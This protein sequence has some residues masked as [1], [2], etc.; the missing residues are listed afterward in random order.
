MRIR[1]RALSLINKFL[2]DDGS[3]DKLNFNFLGKNSHVISPFFIKN[4]Q[5]I[6]IGENFS[7]LYNLRL[8]AWDEYVGQKFK[9]ELIIGNNVC[10]N[11][12]V[13]IGCIDRIEIG[14]NVLMASRIFIADCS[15]GHISREALRLPP[16]QRP[17][18][19]KG[20]VIIENNVW[21]GEGV[22]ILH[23]VTI[24]E[25]SIIGANSVITKDIPSNS[26]VGGNPG[27]ILKTL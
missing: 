13:H 21:I 9:P 3:F 5:Y 8:E 22:A 16:I 27:R 14:D 25:N 6:R 11:S 24:G 12:D 20:P 23:G 4:P 19:S 18:I 1:K 7:S 2:L 10:F 17:L 26:V 15:H